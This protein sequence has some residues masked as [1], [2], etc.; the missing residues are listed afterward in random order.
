MKKLS[1]LGGLFAILLLIGQGCANGAVNQENQP[2]VDEPIKIG[3]VGPLTGDLSTVGES[4]KQSVELAVKE[5]NES[6]GVDGREVEVIYEDGGCDA[7]MASTAGNKLINVDQVQAIIGGTCSGETLAIAPVAEQN[8]V[9]MVSP[10]STAPSVSEAGDYVFR[11][12]PSDSFQGNFAAEYIYNDLEVR[13]VAVLNAVTDYTSG[14]ADSFKAKFQELGGEV[15][16]EDTFLQ[17]DRDLKTQLTK[18]KNSDAELIYFMSYTEAAVIGLKQAKELGLTQKIFGA[19]A[20]DD[21]KLLN[22]D[23]AEGMLYTVPKSEE[24]EDFKQKYLAAVGGDSLP[25]YTAQSYDAINVLVETMKKVGTDREA[26]KNELYS[27]ASYK[28]VSG[29]IAFDENGD[30]TSALYVVKE[31]KDGSSE[32]VVE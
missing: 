17:D 32:E 31:I 3:W 14:L 12:V 28:G 13:K 25:V 19:D 10:A 15:V 24:S 29:D 5:V 4:M 22:V 6:G 8:K 7:K 30:L 20:M 1:F 9:L 18:V 26:V 2:K 16:V 21:P 23:G 11:V 27:V